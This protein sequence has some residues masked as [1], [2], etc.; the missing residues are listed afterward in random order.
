MKD[1]FKYVLATIVGIILTSVIM[2]VICIVSMAGMMASENMSQPVQENSILRIKLQGTISEKGGDPN[3]LGFLTNGEMEDIALDQ[4][5][6]ALKKAAKNDKVKGIYLEG[7]SLSATPAELQELR[8][9]LVEFKKSG[10]WIVSYADQ[11]SRGAY[12]LCSTADKVYMNPIGMLD[13]SGMSSEPIFYKGLLEKV[14]VKMQVFKV[15]TYKSAVEPYINDKMSDANREQVTSYL[16]SIWGNMLKDV[17]KSRKMT[18]EALNSLADSVSLLSDPEAS[19]KGGLVDK[20]CYKSEVKEKLKKRLEL[21][22]DDNLTF[23]TMG[24]VANSE[25]LNEKVDEEIAIYYAYGEIVDE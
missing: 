18:V 17:A 13:W 5:L 10:K 14:G 3:P 24:D 8:Q 1:F 19:V 21:E 25:N 4:A 9:A 23:T 2:T 6:D 20:L 11:Y 15:G 7:G 22:D 16:S 12:Y